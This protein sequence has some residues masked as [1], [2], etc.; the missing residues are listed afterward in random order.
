MNEIEKFIVKKL[1]LNEVDVKSIRELKINP[2]R[3][4]N[5][6]AKMHNKFYRHYEVKTNCGLMFIEKIPKNDKKYKVLNV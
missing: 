4:L 2:L 6:N 3:T 5:I 1:G